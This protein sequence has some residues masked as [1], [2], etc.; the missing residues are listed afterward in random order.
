MLYIFAGLPG[1]GKTEIAR[2]A[3][4]KL[5]AAYLNEDEVLRG[6]FPDPKYTWE[7]RDRVYDGMF[8]RAE[9]ILSKNEDVVLDAT[10]IFERHRTRAK[11]LARK[12]DARC[13]LIEIKAEE[14]EIRKRLERRFDDASFEVYLKYKKS[15]ESIE[16]KHIVVENNGSA[17]EAVENL[18]SL[19]TNR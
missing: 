4:P 9:A 17:V 1:A 16:E 3:A 18:L 10:F 5:G 19:I 13:L 15:Q 7:E 11:N 8:K 6:L 2:R 12:Y 14:E